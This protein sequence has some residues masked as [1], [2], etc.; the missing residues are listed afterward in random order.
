[1]PKSIRYSALLTL[2]LTPAWLAT[3]TAWAMWVTL[4]TP[5]WVRR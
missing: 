1:M 2:A 5:W 4:L 3:V